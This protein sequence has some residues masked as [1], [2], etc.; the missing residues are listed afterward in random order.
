MNATRGLVRWPPPA[1]EQGTG[2]SLQEKPQSE[3]L[4]CHLRTG[5]P[6]PVSE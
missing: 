1:R 2:P 5:K 4:G 6:S 3:T